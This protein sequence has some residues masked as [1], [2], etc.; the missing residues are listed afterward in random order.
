MTTHVFV[1]DGTTLKMHLENLFAGT[2]AKDNV[3]DFNSVGET[4]LPAKTETL[5]VDMIADASRIRS[6]DYVV[7]YLQQNLE[8]DILDGKFYGILKAVNNWSFLDNLRH[9]SALLRG[10]SRGYDFTYPTD[11]R[12][13]RIREYNAELRTALTQKERRNLLRRFQTDE[14][15][16][17][18]DRFIDDF[19]AANQYL[20]KDLEK[21]LTFRTLIE[22]HQ[23]Y[24]EGVTEWEALDEIR[25]IHSPNQMLWSLIYRKLKGNRGN[26][27]ITI[28]ESERLCQ[29][30]R[31]KNNRTTLQTDRRR[32]SF[33]ADSERISVLDQPRTQYEGRQE[34]LNIFPLLH[35]RSR[36]RNRAFEKHLQA[37]LTKNLGTGFNQSLDNTV[38]AGRSLEWMGNEVGCGVG[39]RKIDIML[40][41]AQGSQQVVV[42]IELKSHHADI[43]AARQLARYVEWIRQYYIPN[44]H[45]DIGPVLVARAYARKDSPQYEELL[46]SF[47]EFNTANGRDCTRLKYIECDVNNE[48]IVF[49]EID[50]PNE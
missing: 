35:Q 1:V 14:D 41:L 36:Q 8:E 47:R 19:Y 32:L 6:G 39:M 43:T 29:L 11:S 44:R 27:M 25:D 34:D 23:V 50:Y 37:Y 15:K 20:L 33:D 21:S 24:A 17:I 28:Y 40:S 4:S 30:I 9:H 18:I 22:P 16:A 26:T 48:G 12:K 42:P 13:F 46:G 7:F 45:S 3:I 49:E 10:L 38:L 2:G 31:N 5:L